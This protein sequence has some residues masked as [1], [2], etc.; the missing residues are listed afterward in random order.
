MLITGLSPAGG[1]RLL[2]HPS[3]SASLFSVLLS[4]QEASSKE[5]ISEGGK[6]ED[7]GPKQLHTR[8][9][10]D[11]ENRADLVV[12]HFHTAEL[13]QNEAGTITTETGQGG[14]QPDLHIPNSTS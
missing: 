5:D 2:S 1:K 9:F 14:K 11:I 7:W 6:T 4:G 3:A 13:Q 8:H 12:S 10:Q